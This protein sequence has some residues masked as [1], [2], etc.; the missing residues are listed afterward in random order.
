MITSLCG[1]TIGQEVITDNGHT[2][3]IKAFNT[4]PYAG[5]GTERF[6]V[7]YEDGQCSIVTC[8][9]KYNIKMNFKR[10]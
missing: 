1:F 7:S 8:K 9:N 5:D 10:L 6:K 2:H 4:M 3:I